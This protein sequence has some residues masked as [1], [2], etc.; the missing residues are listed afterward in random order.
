MNALDVWSMPSPSRDR[1][2]EEVRRIM[3]RADFS[4]S[5]PSLIY[6]KEEESMGGKRDGETYR[7]KKKKIDREDRR[8]WNSM[9]IMN[10]SEKNGVYHVGIMGASLEANKIMRQEWTKRYSFFSQVVRLFVFLKSVEN[11]LWH[12]HVW[13]GWVCQQ[14]PWPR[15]SQ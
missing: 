14:R 11:S 3:H 5:R 13:P 12:C 10:N 1:E 6:K 2:R 15:T 9:R 4:L 7:A 8:R